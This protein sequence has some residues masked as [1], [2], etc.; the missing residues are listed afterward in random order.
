[1]DQGCDSDIDI[2]A[3]RDSGVSQCNTG[4]PQQ[5]ILNNEI[6]EDLFPSDVDDDFPLTYEPKLPTV[7]APDHTM[8]PSQDRQQQ[9]D[10][11]LITKC[12]VVLLAY[13]WTFFRISDNAMEFLLAGLGKFFAIAA[14]TIVFFHF[15]CVPTITVCSS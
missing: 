15:V 2:S 11:N 9:R 1:M 12:L 3:V 13:F 6:W 5:G 10:G 7:N 8:S 4:I 14:A